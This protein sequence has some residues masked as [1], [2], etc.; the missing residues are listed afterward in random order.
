MTDSGVA[1]Y[2][3]LTYTNSTIYDHKKI[4]K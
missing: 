4:M 2:V 3:H 1:S